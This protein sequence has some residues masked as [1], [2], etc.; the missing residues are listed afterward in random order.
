M[1]STQFVQKII[2]DYDDTLKMYDEFSN[3]MTF[4]VSKTFLGKTLK[5][6]FFSY[7]GINNMDAMLRFRT[8]YD[9]TDGLQWIVGSDVFVGD[10]SGGFGQFHDNSMVYTKLTYSF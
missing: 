1:F 2:F 5:L 7:F 9:I 3:M 6:E 4:L 8:Y 10:E